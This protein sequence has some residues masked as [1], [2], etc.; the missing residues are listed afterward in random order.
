ML[1]SKPCTMET[2]IGGF[3]GSVWR[4]RPG[5]QANYSTYTVDCMPLKSQSRFWYTMLVVG[6]CH[7]LSL[8]PE[9]ENVEI[10]KI[11]LLMVD[12]T[13]VSVMRSVSRFTCRKT[14]KVFKC[15]EKE[16]RHEHT[17]AA[18]PQFA[19]TRRRRLLRSTRLVPR[20]RRAIEAALTWRG[21]QS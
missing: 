17:D 5:G 18:R 14:G 10:L 21:I 8:Q 4:F 3:I 13:T 15:Q 20:W 12:Y 6:I 16:T 19:P 1:P 7:E 2:V 9:E 11:S